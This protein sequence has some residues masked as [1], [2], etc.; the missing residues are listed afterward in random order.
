MRS[1]VNNNNNYCHRGVGGNVMTSYRHTYRVILGFPYN[2][3]KLY[4]GLNQWCATF[5]DPPLPNL[6]I[7]P[8]RPLK[9]NQ[10]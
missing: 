5:L 6:F 3:R 1:T 9:P 7:S 4:R 8:R 10:H 2:Q